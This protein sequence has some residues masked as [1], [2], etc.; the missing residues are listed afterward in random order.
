MTRWG[1]EVR[2]LV[3]HSR[4]PSRSRSR[5]RHGEVPGPPTSATP[6]ISLQ[7]SPPRRWEPTTRTE[8]AHHRMARHRRVDRRTRVRSAPR[9]RSR[10]VRLDS[11]PHLARGHLG[12]RVRARGCPPPL[13]AR[14]RALRRRARVA[15]GSRSARRRRGSGR[16]RAQWIANASITTETNDHML[17]RV[18]CSS[19]SSRISDASGES[20]QDAATRRFLRPSAYMCGTSRVTSHVV[21]KRL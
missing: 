7:G 9:G 16:K 19:A 8:R 11:S 15:R 12:R 2:F 21:R 18:P 1:S 6:V 4:H 13:V 10:R 5:L 20:D 17:W 3:R 14:R